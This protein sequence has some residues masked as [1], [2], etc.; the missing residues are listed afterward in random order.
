MITAAMKLHLFLLHKYSPGGS[1]VSVD[2]QCTVS[3]C[4]T[5]R[6]RNNQL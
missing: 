1:T 6:T 5:F 3:D 2:K 4:D